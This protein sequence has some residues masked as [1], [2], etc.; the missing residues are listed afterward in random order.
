M[1]LKEKKSCGGHFR[2][3]HQT[4]EGEAKRNDKSY[5]HVAVW[6]Y[7]KGEKPKRHEEKL[8]FENVSLTTR[9]YK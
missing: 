2:E 9:S 4:D 7:Q 8:K 5:A 1:L 6:E 3:E